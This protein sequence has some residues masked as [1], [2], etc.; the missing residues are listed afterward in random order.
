MQSTDRQEDWKAGSPDKR[1]CVVTTWPNREKEREFSS[2]SRDYAKE[3]RALTRRTLMGKDTR[4]IR[5]SRFRNSLHP[6]M[7]MPDCMKFTVY[8]R[9]YRVHSLHAD[10]PAPTKLEHRYSDIKEQDRGLDD[11]RCKTNIIH[12]YRY[13]LY[14]I[15]RQFVLSQRRFTVCDLFTA[16]RYSHFNRIVPFVLDINRVKL[17][18]GQY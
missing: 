15:S 1:G 18:A 7:K 2:R 5:D 14:K 16:F 8:S 4:S 9:L 11:G 12:A 13:T 17:C 6:L 3:Q 10:R